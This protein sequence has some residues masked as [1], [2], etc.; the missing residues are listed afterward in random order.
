MNGQGLLIYPDGKM[1]EGQFINGEY[2]GNKV[3]QHFSN[4]DKFEGILQDG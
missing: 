4:G 1:H 3:I 2:V